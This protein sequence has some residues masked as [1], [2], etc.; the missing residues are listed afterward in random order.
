MHSYVQI[1]PLK[2]RRIISLIFQA[3]AILIIMNREHLYVLLRLLWLLQS[4]DAGC[5]K[6]EQVSGKD[7]E[8]RRNKKWPKL[9]CILFQTNE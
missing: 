3:L 5:I 4:K 6:V 9:L 7:A 2:K 1:L 8:K